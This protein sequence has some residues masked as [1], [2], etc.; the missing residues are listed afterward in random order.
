LT[1]REGDVPG[2]RQQV[3]ESEKR[4]ALVSQ[5]PV[6]DD[7]QKNEWH[8]GSSL[9]AELASMRAEREQ[10][11][12]EEK[13]AKERKQ[14]TVRKAQLDEDEILKKAS[15]ASNFRVAE[16]SSLREKLAQ[17]K[18]AVEDVLEAADREGE[19]IGFESQAIREKRYEAERQLRE[20]AKKVAATLKRINDVQTSEKEQLLEKD[21][22]LAKY[23]AAS[24]LR[25]QQLQKEA[26][27]RCTQ[28]GRSFMEDMQT[29]HKSVL[30]AHAEIGLGVQEEVARRLKAM[31]SAEDEIRDVDLA[32]NDGLTSVHEEVLMLQE[33][34]REQVKE[35]QVR[36]FAI[37]ELIVQK[38]SDA[39][40]AFEAASTARSQAESSQRDAKQRRQGA[41]EAL[42][43]V[44]PKSSQFN[45]YGMKMEQSPH[46][47]RAWH[48]VGNI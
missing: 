40:H 21:D 1:R 38:V 30:E 25:V 48:M 14:E 35:V 33:K 47:S 11:A 39:M 34:A 6:D 8:F 45:L 19:S 12:K 29:I 22:M 2:H 27:E 4:S 42:G 24:R 31:G 7:G 13:A 17:V 18:D 10:L 16:F 5:D 20:E 41:A 3:M 37:E 44:F 32:V 9:D 28:L 23:R 26:E 36:D 15:E 46:A 43:D